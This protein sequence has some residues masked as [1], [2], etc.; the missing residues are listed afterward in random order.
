MATQFGEEMQKELMAWGSSDPAVKGV[1]E[2][3]DKVVRYD[4]E[5]SGCDMVITR[6]LNGNDTGKLFIYLSQTDGDG[7]AIAFIKKMKGGTREAITESNLRSFLDGLSSCYRETLETGSDCIPKIRKD[8]KFI[9]LLLNMLGKSDMVQLMRKGLISAEV[10]WRYRDNSYRNIMPWYADEDRE[11]HRNWNPV[12]LHERVWDHILGR[13]SEREGV[14]RGDALEMVWCEGA[15]DKYRDAIAFEFFADIFDDFFA[16]KCFDEYIDNA[17]LSG[18][19]RDRYSSTGTTEDIKKLF[20][21]RSWIPGTEGRYKGGYYGNDFSWKDAV[22]DMKEQVPFFVRFDK[23][24]FWDYLQH[25]ICLGLGSDLNTF[26]TH[27]RD[28]LVAAL[29]C[30]GKLKDKYPEY[31]QVAHDIYSE[32]ARIIKDFRDNER[33]MQVTETPSQICDMEHNGMMLRTL[34]TI[35]D[36][37]LEAQQNANC[38]ATYVQ[39]T[40]TGNSWVCSFRSAKSDVT[41]LTVEIDKL[42]VMCQIKGKYNRQPTAKE[43][44]EL[45]WFQKEVFKRMAEKE[46]DFGQMP[47]CFRDIEEE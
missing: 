13:I 34:R 1:R 11:Y 40:L 44:K 36:Y 18:L 46:M 19:R 2:K 28:Y 42:G 37:T 29:Q 16:I 10:V 26:I 21:V 15:V 41:L 6:N 14:G 3:K 4:I 12:R 47:S 45:R 7:K 17:R 38:V 8:T 33:L 43:F 39:H 23:N 22:E 24:R 30:D 31:L 35:N 20:T 25:S 5:V 9:K 32:K 27:W